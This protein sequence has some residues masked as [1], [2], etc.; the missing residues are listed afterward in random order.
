M[1]FGSFK[2]NNLDNQE[3]LYKKISSDYGS[4]DCKAAGRSFGNITLHKEYYTSENMMFIASVIS[5]PERPPCVYRL[6]IGGNSI[7]IEGLIA[8]LN[9]RDMGE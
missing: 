1:G 5:T 2:I 7:D 4:P 8:K 6:I 9:L 3:N